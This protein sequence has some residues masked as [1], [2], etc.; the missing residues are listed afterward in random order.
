MLSCS[1]AL[2]VR[3]QWTRPCCACLTCGWG[4]LATVQRRTCHVDHTL[5]PHVLY[6]T[7]LYCTALD[8]GNR[9]MIACCVHE[10]GTSPRDTHLMLP[11]AE[12]LRTPP[13]PCCYFTV[14]CYIA[15]GTSLMSSYCAHKLAFPPM[16]SLQLQQSTA[17]SCL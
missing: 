2:E 16:R 12:P 17:L 1:T 5:C 14:L 7:V 3:W 9:L 10:A 6:S 8:S 15:A 4:C 11:R 13:T